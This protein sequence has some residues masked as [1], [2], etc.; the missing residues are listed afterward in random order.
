MK[1]D[2]IE[3]KNKSVIKHSKATIALFDAFVEV[4]SAF[5]L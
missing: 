2:V 1:R 5:S 3:R 4:L